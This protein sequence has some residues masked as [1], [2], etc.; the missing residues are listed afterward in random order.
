MQVGAEPTGYGAPMI[1]CSCWLVGLMYS[2]DS[3]LYGV[4]G[5]VLVVE[6]FATYRYLPVLSI[7]V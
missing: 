3:E 6:L 1:G 2:A 5:W 7:M 4:V